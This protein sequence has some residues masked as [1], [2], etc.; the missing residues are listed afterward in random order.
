MSGGYE[1]AVGLEV[2]AELATGT[3]LFCG[4]RNRFGAEPNTLCCPVC[5]GMPGH[6][7]G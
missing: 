7:R 4:C 2:H 3:K 5:L 6:C 1:I